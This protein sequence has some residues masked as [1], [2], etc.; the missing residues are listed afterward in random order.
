MKPLVR[1]AVLEGLCNSGKTS[2][3]RALKRLQA[4]DENDERSVVILGEHYSQ[5]LQVTEDG[6]VRLEREAH[7]ALL[8]ERVECIEQL[9]DWAMKL[10]PRRRRSR[11]LFYVFERFHLNH[12]YAYGDSDRIADLEG[13]IAD[14]GGVCFLLTVSSHDIRKRLV[15]RDRNEL[16]GRDLER[17]CAEWLEAQERMIQLTEA[18]KLPTVM[19]NTDERDWV[20]YA[21]EI[22]NVTKAR[23]DAGSEWPGQVG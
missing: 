13:R 20:A 22:L 8:R 14:L 5:Q 10:G 7:A 16:E 23:S 3:L 2:L 1:G 11:G 4:K 21:T 12:R 6:P 19:I 18:S 15:H 17:V 9:N